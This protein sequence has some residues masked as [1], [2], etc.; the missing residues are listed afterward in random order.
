M[1][2]RICHKLQEHKFF[3][4]I[5]AKSLI[6]N[7]EFLLELVDLV[8]KKIYYMGVAEHD[9]AGSIKRF[10]TDVPFGVLLFRGLDSFFSGCGGIMTSQ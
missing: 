8:L 10:M 4:E 2:F 6:E 3:C 1:L 5:Y 9:L 7:K